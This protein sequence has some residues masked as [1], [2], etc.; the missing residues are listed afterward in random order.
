MSGNQKAN[1]IGRVVD[2]SKQAPIR[3]AKIVFDNNDGNSVVSYSDIEGIYRFSANPNHNGVLQGQITVEA[4]GYRTY[5]SNI[6][7]PEDNKD[8][9]DITLLQ[10][11][12]SKTRIQDVEHTSS[13]SSKPSMPNKPSTPDKPNNKSNSTNSSDTDRLMPIL[14]ALMVTFFTFTTFAIVSAIRK[15]RFN[16]RRDNYINFHQVPIHQLKS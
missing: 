15:E 14:I 5:K 3:A 11:S 16:D 6:N 7:S 13:T 1:Y 4:N 10:G 12:G 8:L 2:G 9:G